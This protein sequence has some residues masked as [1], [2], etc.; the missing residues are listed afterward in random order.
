MHF[1]CQFFNCFE[2]ETKEIASCTD[3]G[4]VL[5]RCGAS[6]DRL[7]RG[8]LKSSRERVQVFPGNSMELRGINRFHGFYEIPDNS[9]EFHCGQLESLEFQGIT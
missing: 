7:F 8:I 4:G 3:V 6:W 1:G 5:G 9:K 2:K